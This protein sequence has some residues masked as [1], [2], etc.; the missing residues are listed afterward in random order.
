MLAYLMRR[1]SVALLLLWGVLTLTFAIVHLAPGDPV[2]LMV[3]PDMSTT[4]IA[5]LRHSLGLDQ[6]LLAQYRDWLAATL[7]GDL[8]STLGITTR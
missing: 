6:P 7:R 8:G 1:I 3:Q 4:D 5:Q 2:E